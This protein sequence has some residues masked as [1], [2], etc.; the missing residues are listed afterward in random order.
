MRLKQNSCIF[1]SDN[2]LSQQKMFNRLI[3]ISLILCILSQFNNKYSV[4]CNLNH[5][6]N[7][8]RCQRMTAVTLNPALMKTRF[9]LPLRNTT[10]T[11]PT[12]LTA[13]TA[14][15]SRPR[16]QTNT[17][18]PAQHGGRFTGSQ[19]QMVPA[20]LSVVSNHV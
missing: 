7:F 2:F 19:L 15:C 4:Y 18:P 1:L 17:N 6:S 8:P 16:V 12:G 10:L 5:L 20:S 14:T 13:P 3:A 9:F 11:G